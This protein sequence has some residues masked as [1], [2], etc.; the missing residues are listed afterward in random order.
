MSR[1]IASASHLPGEAISN[2]QLIARYQLESSD[3][4]IW[5]RTG[6]QARYFAESDQSVA[7]LASVA[8]KRLVA[9]LNSTQ[10]AQ[11]RQII[12]A[13]MSAGSA[14][15]SVASQV[16][17]AIEAPNAWAVDVNGA[18]SGFIMALEIAN[19]LSQTQLSGYTLVIGAEKM[20]Q[21]LNF[22]DRSTAILF[23]DGAA[24]L[25][26][27]HDGQP[28]TQFVSRL[29]SDGTKGAAIQIATT[30]QA[31]PTMQMEGRDVFNF[32]K[33]TVIPDLAQLIA[34]YQ[35][36]FDY[37]ICHQANQRLLNLFADKLALTQEQ[38]PSN[39][40]QVANTSA[41]SIPLLIDHL[42]QTGQLKLDGTQRVLLSGF[43]AGLAWGHSYLS[44]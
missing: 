35:L 20:S 7:D 2:K 24:G 17:A 29:T 21:I 10:R 15:P 40:A 16:Q 3:E 42:V 39:I 14:T 32:V 25:L 28:L 6:I 38:V 22:N 37:L 11:I 34:E 44:L 23:G 41:A 12:V 18:C 13:T 27:E 36:D 5:Q 9:S 8:A 4:W 1:V 43:G 19:A 30:T 31:Y 26:I 33:R